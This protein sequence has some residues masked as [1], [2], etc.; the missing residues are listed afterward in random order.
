MFSLNRVTKKK[1]KVMEKCNQQI[2]EGVVL[3]SVDTNDKSAPCLDPGTG[4]RKCVRK[5]VMEELKRPVHLRCVKTDDRSAPVIE[6]VHITPSVQSA[7]C[8]EIKM[9]AL[10]QEISAGVALKS[11][12]VN[13]K[14]APVIEPGT[15]VRRSCDPVVSREL[16][17]AVQLRSTVTN[18][19]SAPFIESGIKLKMDSRKKL[20]N[21]IVNRG[22]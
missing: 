3:R 11:A 14:T 8:H 15:V 13:D 2:R 6:A 17:E 4:A 19:K 12:T 21:E 16:I 10:K 5:D 9:G 18:D 1:K 22:V 20:M 7:L